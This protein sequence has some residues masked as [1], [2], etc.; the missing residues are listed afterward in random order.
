MLCNLFSH[1][2]ISQSAME[3]FGK[4]FQT[5]VHSNQTRASVTIRAFGMMPEHSNYICLASLNCIKSLRN[6]LKCMWVFFLS[7]VPFLVLSVSNK[8]VLKLF[9]TFDDYHSHVPIQLNNQ[10]SGIT[11]YTGEERKVWADPKE[12]DK[13]WRENFYFPT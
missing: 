4:V 7:R 11:S 10:C 3:T 9:I 13:I 8:W 12:Q 1:Y 5:S 6:R 2:S